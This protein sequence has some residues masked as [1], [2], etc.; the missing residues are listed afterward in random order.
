MPML[1]T[2]CCRTLMICACHARV[3]SQLFERHYSGRSNRAS[4]IDGGQ[5]N[6]ERSPARYVR[7]RGEA[8][9]RARAHAR[10]PYNSGDIKRET[11]LSLVRTA[12]ISAATI[13]RSVSLCARRADTDTHTCACA[14]ITS[15]PREHYS[16]A[17]NWAVSLAQVSAGYCRRQQRTP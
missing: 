1:I 8:R 5:R 13:D 3:K 16:A 15:H 7:G 9:A 10:T 2:A 12:E 11:L 6:A 14:A 17:G 4:K